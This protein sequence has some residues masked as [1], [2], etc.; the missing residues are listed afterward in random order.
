[1][2]IK[3]EDWLIYYK[4]TG[5]RLA[6]TLKAHVHWESA[7]CWKRLKAKDTVINVD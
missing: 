2:P 1:M 6:M 4:T 3:T 7:S 5:K